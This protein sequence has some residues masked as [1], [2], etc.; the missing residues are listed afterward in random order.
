MGEQVQ[1]SF[2]KTVLPTQQ[3]VTN[4]IEIEDHVPESSIIV[5]AE[6]VNNSKS[7]FDD[8]KNDKYV[9]LYCLFFEIG[10]YEVKN[11]SG[12]LKLKTHGHGLTN[13]KLEPN[14]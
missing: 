11:I 14:G 8:K 12:L 6:T 2:D 13:K 9:V 3:N 1:I 10:D 5:D 4:Y 7:K